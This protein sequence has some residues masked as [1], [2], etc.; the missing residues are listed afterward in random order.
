M[1]IIRI[2]VL[3]ILSA[4]L[5][6]GPLSAQTLYGSLTGNVTDASGAAVPNAKIETLNVATGVVKT[7]LT[8]DRGAYLLSDLQPGSYKVK[9]GR[10]VQQECRDRSRMPSSA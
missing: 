9:I 3:A 5:A 7:A 1:Q 10:A 4:L 2:L 8:D 6:T